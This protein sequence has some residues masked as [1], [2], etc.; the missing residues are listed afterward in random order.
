[1]CRITDITVVTMSH[2]TCFQNFDSSPEILKLPL[3][4][5]FLFSA[6]CAG[7][8]PDGLRIKSALGGSTTLVGVV[9]VT[10]TG[11]GKGYPGTESALDT[12]DSLSDSELV[13]LGNPRPESTLDIGFCCSKLSFVIDFDFVTLGW[14]GGPGCLGLGPGFIRL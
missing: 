1:M 6:S 5:L 13:I 2:K 8:L 12:L 9:T 11:E 3:R 4:R 7:L 14:R 10:R